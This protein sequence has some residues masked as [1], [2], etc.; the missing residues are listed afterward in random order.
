MVPSPHAFSRFQ[1]RPSIAAITILKVGNGSRTYRNMNWS[2]CASGSSSLL[3]CQL[4]NIIPKSPN[5]I[6]LKNL[7]FNRDKCDL[8]L[9]AS[10]FSSLQ[11]GSSCSSSEAS[12][13]HRATLLPQIGQEG[14]RSSLFARSAALFLSQQWNILCFFEFEIRVNTN[15]AMTP[16]IHAGHVSRNLALVASSHVLFLTYILGGEC[17]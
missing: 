9:K 16:S 5:Q 1:C 3:S 6:K 10:K 14:N 8:K 17:S 7:Q 15:E 4:R 12:W 2:W 11:V 13:Q